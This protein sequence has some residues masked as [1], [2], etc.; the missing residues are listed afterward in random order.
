MGSGTFCT[1]TKGPLT[2]GAV[3]TQANGF[4]GAYLKTAGFDAV[5]VHGI[6]KRWL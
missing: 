5:V 6:A 3:T 1:V 2:N 4:M